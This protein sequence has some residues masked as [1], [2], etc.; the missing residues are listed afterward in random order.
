MLILKS[1][2]IHFY[3]QQYGILGICLFCLLSIPSAQTPP[4]KKKKKK[5]KK[6][7]RKKKTLL[8]LR[9]MRVV[10]CPSR[11]LG[12]C[13]ASHPCTGTTDQGPA[14]SLRWP[15]YLPQM[16]ES[17]LTMFSKQNN[18]R[19]LEEKEPLGG[20]RNNAISLPT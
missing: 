1:L 16:P 14:R 8:L 13:S 15:F 19:N 10:Q 2:D 20:K 9:Q 17:Y 5:L 7:K 4:K 6:K 18:N 12:S 11:Y 3:I